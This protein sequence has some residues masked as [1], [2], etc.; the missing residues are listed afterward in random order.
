MAKERWVS[1]LAEPPQRA[2]IIGQGPCPI[3][4]M[5]SVERHHRILHRANIHDVAS[6]P[7]A[8]PASEPFL[9]LRGDYAID[10]S[11]LRGLVDAPGSLLLADDEHGR[12]VAIAAHVSNG[13]GLAVRELMADDAAFVD[14]HL[15]AGMRALRPE[16]LGPSYNRT[17][18]KR[19]QPYAL[20]VTPS[21]VRGLEWRT[22]REAYKG[23]TDFVTKLAWP[24]PAFHVTRWCAHRQIS[25]N[26]VTTLGLVLMLIAT[27]LFWNGWFLT[28]ALLGWA[29]TFLDTVDGKLARCTLTSS[30]WG[31]IYDHGID[32]VHPPVWYFAWWAG[33]GAAGEAAAF[34]INPW[35][36]L[37]VILGGYLAGRLMELAFKVF[38]GIQTHVWQPVDYHFR[39]ITARRNPNLAIL[40]VAAL[41]GRPAEGLVLVAAWTVISLLFHLVRILQ[42]ARA[43]ARG[44]D[45]SS[46][47]TR[48]AAGPAHA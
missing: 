27:V 5:T 20:Q 29:M 42:A 14:A 23:A 1:T 12:T 22:F 39:A 38:Y 48:S 34:G 28:G 4:G 32:L 11:L 3:W 35:L 18:R 26:M 21:S 46:W 37:W 41:L 15:P 33:L 2:V 13:D 43:R 40:T 8:L 36:A 19:A 24:I 25:P 45:I 6:E 47:M 31:D 10:E 7:A 16:E 9:M 17:L 44:E 30:K